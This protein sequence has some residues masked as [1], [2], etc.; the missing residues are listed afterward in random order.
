MTTIYSLTNLLFVTNEGLLLPSKSTKRF[1]TGLSGGDNLLGREA[2]ASPMSSRRTSFTSFSQAFSKGA[3]SSEFDENDYRKV[4]E[5]AVTGII[6]VCEKCNDESVPAL[7]CTILS[8]KVSK[9]DSPIGPLILKGLSSCAPFLPEREFVILIRLLNKISFDALEKKNMVLMGYLTES[10][11]LLAEKLK[12]SNPLFTVYLHEL[13]QA[14][15]SK[16][17]VQQLEHHRS[18]NEIS[19][20][21]DQIAIYLKPLAALLPDVHL[22]EKPLEIKSTVTINLFRNIWF[23]MVVHGYNIN[24]KNTKTFRNELERIA[25]NSPPLASELSWTE[26]KLPL[27]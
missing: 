17:D 8:Q 2:F 5:N 18:H 7:T 26:P 15:N 22:G 11:V 25:Y 20:V 10:K 21:G 13:L 4:C 14:I 9:I 1:N 23:N 27:N 6:E 3:N 16:G 24:S 12:V 19:E